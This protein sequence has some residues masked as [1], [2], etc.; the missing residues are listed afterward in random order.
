MVDLFHFEEDCAHDAAP[1]GERIE[2]SEPE[3]ARVPN[4]ELG[5]MS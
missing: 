1:Q 3:T 5:A 4:S 2:D